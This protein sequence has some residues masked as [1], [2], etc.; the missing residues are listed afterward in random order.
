MFA[1]IDEAR[2]RAEECRR[3][4]ARAINTVDVVAWLSQADEWRKLGQAGDMGHP[5]IAASRQPTIRLASSP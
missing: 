4:A 5:V 1:I 3:E 2:E